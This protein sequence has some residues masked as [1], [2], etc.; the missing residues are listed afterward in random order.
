MYRAAS[1]FP[2]SVRDLAL[3]VDAATPYQKVADIIAASPLVVR[4]ALFDVYSGERIPAGKKSL[5]CR[6]VY[7]SPDHTLTDEEV[8]RVQKKTLARL[9][10]D[11]GAML[12]G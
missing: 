6:V 2:S 3:V 5:A 12:R 1:R 7:Q 10:R 8:N 11:L 4:V 9:S